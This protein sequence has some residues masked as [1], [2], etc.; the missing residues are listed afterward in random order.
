MHTIFAKYESNSGQAINFQKS[1][2][3]LAEM[4]PLR[5]KILSLIFLA[6]PLLLTLEDIL[7]FSL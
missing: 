3:F 6:F 2:I 1:G 5:I 4:S 7:G